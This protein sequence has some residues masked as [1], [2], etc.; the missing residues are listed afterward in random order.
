MKKIAIIGGAGFVGRHLVRYLKNRGYIPKILD[1]HED[2]TLQNYS[3]VNIFDKEKLEFELSGIDEVFHLAAV[4]GVE[5]CIDQEELLLKTSIE[6][7]RNVIDACVKNRVRKLAFTSSSEVYGDGIKIPFTETDSLLPKSIYGKAK[8]ACEEMLMSASKDIAVRIVR[9][10]N[11]YGPGQRDDFVITKFLHRLIHN[12]PLYIYG[13]GEQIRCFTY[14]TDAVHGLVKALEYD[15]ESN[16]EV[17][18]IG[19]NTPTTINQLVEQMIKIVDKEMCNLTH[20]K[21]GS[22]GIRSSDIEVFRR[23][24]DTTKAE[25]LLNFKAETDLVT[26]LKETLQSCLANLV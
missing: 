13:D 5:R 14:I 9:F 19:N 8:V 15:G 10:F 24:P 6:G 3:M 20:A 7:T 25:K 23:I 12:V 11:V 16:F 18:N 2:S 21:L 26:G 17:F 4:V 1:I 22:H